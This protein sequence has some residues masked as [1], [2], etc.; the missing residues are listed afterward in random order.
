MTQINPNVHFVVYRPKSQEDYSETFKQLEAVGMKPFAITGYK[1]YPDNSDSTYLTFSPIFSAGKKVFTD[2][3]TGG[4]GLN[5]VTQLIESREDFVQAVSTFDGSDISPD[6]ALRA[7][8]SQIL[9][10]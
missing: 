5:D 8:M 3:N 9:G 2:G 7:I 10:N 6:A 1:E 4:A